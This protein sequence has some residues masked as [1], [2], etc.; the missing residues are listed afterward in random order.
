MHLGS[1]AGIPGIRVRSLVSVS[2]ISLSSCINL[3]YNLRT[4]NILDVACGQ[5]FPSY[6]RISLSS[7]S[8]NHFNDTIASAAMLHLTS[9]STDQLRYQFKDSYSLSLSYFLAS[10]LRA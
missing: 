1:P 9:Y 8:L 5:F 2:G 3:F 6:I 7:N 10:S 4:D